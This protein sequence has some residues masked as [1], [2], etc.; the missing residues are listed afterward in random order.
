[1]V[2]RSDFQPPPRAYATQCEH[3]RR[4]TTA[5]KMRQSIAGAKSPAKDP[6]PLNLA[7]PAC[8]PP[9]LHPASQQVQRRQNPDGA[10][11]MNPCTSE[12]GEFQIS[13]VLLPC[14]GVEWRTFVC[15]RERTGPVKCL[16]QPRH[17]FF[18]NHHRLSIDLLQNDSVSSTGKQCRHRISPSY[19]NLMHPGPHATAVIFTA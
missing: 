11:T 2:Q 18:L 1:M 6:A 19:E 9:S 10:L 5:I 8:P 3:L 4:T 14:Y 7:F 16:S 13:V 17:C 15:T 12:E